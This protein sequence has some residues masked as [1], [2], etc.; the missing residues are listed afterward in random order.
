MKILL[1]DDEPDILRIYSEMLEG[2]A[3]EVAVAHDGIEALD[4]IRREEFDLLVLDLFM[5]NMDGFETLETLRG[6]GK[7]VPVVVMTGHYPDDEVVE[8]TEGLGVEAVLRKPVLITTLMNAVN[9][10]TSEDKDV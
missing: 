7:Q 8:R 9:K 5:P 3:H 2:N 10:I 6:E 4:L 1:A